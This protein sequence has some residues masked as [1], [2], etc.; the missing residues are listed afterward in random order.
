MV[1]GYTF[2]RTELDCCTNGS[3]SI[4]SPNSFVNATGRAGIDRA[5]NFKVTGSYL[6]PYDIQFGANLR[7]QSGQPFTRTLLITGL[8]QNPNGITVN[9]QPRGTYLLPWLTTADLRVGKIFRVAGVNTFEV[10]MDVYNLTNSNAVYNVRNTTG[11]QNVTDFT[12]GQPVQIAQF[13]SP[14]AVLG[15][16]IIRFNVSYKFGR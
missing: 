6:F 3:T 16:R 2:S 7:A 5:H 11:R 10:D 15:P 13:N 12:T 14:I 4:T 8:N 1:G 9:A